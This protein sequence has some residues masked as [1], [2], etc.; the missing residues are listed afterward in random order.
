MLRTSLPLRTYSRQVERLD[1]ESERDF[2]H[3]AEM[4]IPGLRQYVHG[5]HPGRNLRAVVRYADDMGTATVEVSAL[6]DGLGL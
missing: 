6:K 2:A 3:R 1:G 5:R 4:V